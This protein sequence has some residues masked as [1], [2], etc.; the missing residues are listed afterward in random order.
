MLKCKTCGYFLLRDGKEWRCYG[1]KPR[2]I[3]PSKYPDKPVEPYSHV[4]QELQKDPVVPEK[5]ETINK[6]IEEV[7]KEHVLK[8]YQ[9]TK[10][11]KSKAA[12]I[13]GVSVK[14]LYNKLE[15]YSYDN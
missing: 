6:T 11:N 1:C 3:P 10:F 14:T 5:V 8:V 13:L 4:K 9:S 15:A 12:R 7:I 2:I